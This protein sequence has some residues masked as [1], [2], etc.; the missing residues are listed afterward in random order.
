MFAIIFDK[1]TPINAW[2]LSNLIQ[3]NVGKQNMRI[4][5]HEDIKVP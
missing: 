5:F 4:T 3:T 1:N 2:I